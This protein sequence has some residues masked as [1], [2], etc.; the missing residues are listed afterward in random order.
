MIAHMRLF[1]RH[2]ASGSPE[3][4]AHGALGPAV[5]WAKRR[6]Q[7][8]GCAGCKRINPPYVYA[9]NQKDYCLDCAKLN[10]E[11][12]RLYPAGK[13]TDDIT[14]QDL[15]LDAAS[16]SKAGAGPSP[17]DADQQTSPPDAP[18]EPPAR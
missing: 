11:V 12:L 7:P 18:A 6:R 10:L 17:E 3:E 2:T 4:R 9:E 16:M 15:L 1:K 13:R 8:L 5:D 14:L